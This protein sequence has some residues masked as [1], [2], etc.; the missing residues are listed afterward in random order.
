MPHLLLP[1]ILV[2]VVLTLT[3]GPDMV[4]VLR[5]GSRG[6][7]RAAWWTGLGCCAG[8]A[9]YAAASAL[10]LAAVLAA[11]ATAFLVI[12]LLGAVYL[13]H[14][15]VRALWHSRRAS[16]AAAAAATATSPQAAV[17][18]RWSAFRQGLVSNLLNPKIAL[19]FL[20]L[21]PQ[22]VSPGEPALL[23]TGIL[24]ATFLAL[25]VLWWRV[26]SLAIGGL[27]R[28][29]ARE[30]VRTAVER[31]SGV[32]LIGLGVRVALTANR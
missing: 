14:L 9:V 17:V 27:G 11:S 2:V 16:S 26:F 31:V 28:V 30:R 3:P 18:R 12:K 7:S 15:G 23:T 13:V 1:F 32:V 4:L 20:T 29:L 6:G 22:F 25:A 8:I 10:G 21:I 24:A 19:I 5:N